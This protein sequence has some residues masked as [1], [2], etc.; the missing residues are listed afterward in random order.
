M[1][2]EGNGSNGSRS[3]GGLSSMFRSFRYRNY[4]L[5]FTGQSISLIGTWIQ[6]IA[7][8]WL[9]YHLTNSPFLLG[10]VGFAGQIPTFLVAPFAGVITDR[11]NRYHIMIATQVAA[12]I[13]ALILAALYFKGNIQVW[14]IV[15]LNMF[16]GCI[17]AFDTPARQSFVIQ[18]VEKK[19]DLGNAI[20]L[21]S[22]MV[23]IARLLGPSIA[24]VLI[25]L[26]GEG[27]CFLINGLS[28]IF[29][30]ASLFMMKVEPKEQAKSDKAVIHDLKEGLSYASGFIPIWWTIL[31]LAVVSLMGMSYQTLMPVFAKEIL[32]G[33][34]HT[35]GF[36]MGA[37]GLG[38]LSGALWLASRKSTRGLVNLIPAAAA[39]FGAAL[40][41]FSFSR[42][43]PLSMALLV[44]SG[45]GMM[46]QMAS[47]NT[48]VQTI[49]DDKMRG[50]VM[51]FYTMAFMGTAPF[52]SFMAGAL[53]K[54]VGTP[55]TLVIGGSVC[56][57]GAIIFAQK[58]PAI[59]KQI[60]P[61]YAKQE[62]I[63]T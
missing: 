60:K 25:A 17:N 3:G 39:L 20:A 43:L 36:L 5:F 46:M 52:G 44:L 54:Y 4:R 31:L 35:F 21:N 8:P 41:A 34:S 55:V 7:T 56:I 47:S 59:R 29:V 10:L 37:T 61:A 27:I 58:L 49:V 28:Y 18:M 12:M 33:G 30:I 38:A 13:Q 40:I 23:N 53:A 26:T 19:E 42:Y 16:L 50:R 9:V 51:S 22:S 1:S 6:R 48:L 2:P 62:L 14:E 24:G 11:R 63:E 45:L 32:H 15:V 57:A